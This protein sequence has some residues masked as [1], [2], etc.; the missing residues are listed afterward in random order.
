MIAPSGS[1][2]S[3]VQRKPAYPRVKLLLGGRAH[4]RDTL[5]WT[6]EQAPTPGRTEGAELGRGMGSRY[7]AA[8]IA[9]PPT[10]I[11]IGRETA[12]DRGGECA[13]VTA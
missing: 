12:N 10:R 1:H 6:D 4:Q 7:G 8:A 13:S 3:P 2:F 5:E 11:E 9:T